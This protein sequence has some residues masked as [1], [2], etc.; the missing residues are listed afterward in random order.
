MFIIAILVISLTH[1]KHRRRKYEMTIQWHPIESV[2][3]S[4]LT[5]ILTAY[6]ITTTKNFKTLLY[7]PFVR[8]IHHSLVHSLCKGNVEIISMSWSHQEILA[9]GG[10]AIILTHP[11]LLLIRPLEIHFSEIWMAIQILL[12][13]KT[14]LKMWSGKCQPFCL[15]SNMLNGATRWHKQVT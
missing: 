12:F 2:M 14:H 3:A 11:D 8:G 9:F 5:G 1:L 6:S 7:W 10:Q 15:C 13:K 4:Q